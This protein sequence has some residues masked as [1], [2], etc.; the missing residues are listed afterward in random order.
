M[1]LTFPMR[2]H[3]ARA[4]NRCLHVFA[5]VS[6][7][8]LLAGCGPKMQGVATDAGGGFKKGDPPMCFQYRGEARPTT[9]ANNIW[10]HINNTC[11]YTVDCMVWDD[12]SEQQHRMMA[13]EYQTRSYMVA[14]EV[15][16]RRVD[17]KFDCTWK[18]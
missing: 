1:S 11:S 5:A 16:Q 9:R 15:P 2:A 17:L 7:V 14:G 13:P 10:V 3:L 12:V 4:T 18:P 8:A 6:A